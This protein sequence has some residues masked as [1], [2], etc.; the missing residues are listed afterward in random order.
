MPDRSWDI[1]LSFKY[2]V[3]DSPSSVCYLSGSADVA[4]ENTRR[5]RQRVV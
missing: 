4:V 2:S 1:D 3:I 5:R